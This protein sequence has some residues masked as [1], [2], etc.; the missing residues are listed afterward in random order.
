MQGGGNNNP[1]GDD[2]DDNS[3]NSSIDPRFAGI[4]KDLDVLSSNIVKA[5]NFYKS[6][7]S[8]PRVKEL[9]ENLK[10]MR[11]KMMALIPKLKSTGNSQIVQYS[12]G[13]NN[14]LLSFLNKLESGPENGEGQGFGDFGNFNSSGNTPFQ[15]QTS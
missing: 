6:G 9:Y 3:M 7:N 12:E 11:S 8:E 2:D 10:M 5:E 13:I 15:Q 14:N 4:K 1:F